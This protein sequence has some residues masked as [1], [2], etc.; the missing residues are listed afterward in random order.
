MSVLF[1][2]N[3]QTVGTIGQGIIQTF[4]RVTRL[5]QAE[6]GSIP[7][8]FEPIVSDEIWIDRDSFVKF[9]DE[10]FAQA[11][12]SDKFRYFSYWAGEMAG[13][14]ENVTKTTPVRKVPEDWNFRVR[15][16]GMRD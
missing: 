7:S 8:G 3:Q 6:M 15:R 1:I 9:V 16:Y 2:Y 14:Y 5:V 11:E 12:K 4:L 13:M 10:F